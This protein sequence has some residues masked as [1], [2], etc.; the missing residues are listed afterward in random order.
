MGFLRCLSDLRVAF[1]NSTTS[2]CL[3]T[4]SGLILDTGFIALQRWCTLCTLCAM[5]NGKQRQETRAIEDCISLQTLSNLKCEALQHWMD[6]HGFPHWCSIWCINSTLVFSLFL[7]KATAPFK[8]KVH[9]LPSHVH[10]FFPLKKPWVLDSSASRC[11]MME[12]VRKARCVTPRGDA[13]SWCFPCGKE[14]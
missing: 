11:A 1:H 10:D 12:K 8:G 6:M 3:H 4:T 14:R 2:D 9:V 13:S 7:R 5:A